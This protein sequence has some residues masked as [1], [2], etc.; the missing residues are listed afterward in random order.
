MA[1]LQPGEAVEANGLILPVRLGEAAL[2]LED[3]VPHLVNS[4]D[5]HGTCRAVVAITD[6]LE[7]CA[8][9]QTTIASIPEVDSPI[10]P[11][12]GRD[13]S[14]AV[15]DSWV[16]KGSLLGA[17]G[18]HSVFV[19]FMDVMRRP[20]QGSWTVTNLTLM[21]TRQSV[22]SLIEEVALDAVNS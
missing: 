19:A 8:F 4:A 7:S 16:A 10:M 21:G 13:S 1:C 9:E 2:A 14:V 11:M 6:K 20:F 17:D 22:A 18:T 12:E 15:L 3:I 5:S